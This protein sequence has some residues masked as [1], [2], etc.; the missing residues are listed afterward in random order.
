[1]SQSW[2]QFLDSLNPGSQDTTGL[3]AGEIGNTGSTPTGSPYPGNN[4]VDNG[5]GTWT[6]TSTGI[7]YDSSGISVGNDPSLTDSMNTGGAGGSQLGLGGLLQSLG[8][9]SGGL[10]G[11]A[12]LAGLLGPALAGAYSANQTGK[13]TGQVVQGIQNAQTSVNNLL[14]APST[15]GPYTTAGQ[16]AITKLNG[17]NW[18][19]MNFAPLGGKR[20]TLGNI[21][22]PPTTTTK[23][24]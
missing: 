6:D 15:F 5:N 16:G 1:M 17:M 7:M 14:G 22:A 9:G 13:A 23:G 11:L 18:Q 8:L 12:T 19:P 10:G 21:A 20:I 3:T 2:Q 4:M 24:R